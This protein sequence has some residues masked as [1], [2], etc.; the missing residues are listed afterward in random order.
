M[1]SVQNLSN[2]LKIKMSQWLQLT[3]NFQKWKIS[4]LTRI[5]S[6]PCCIIFSCSSKFHYIN[7][8]NPL[9]LLKNPLSVWETGVV[10]Q[11]LSLWYRILR[12]Y[13]ICFLFCKLK[14]KVIRKAFFIAFYL[15]SKTNWL[16]H[17][18][19]QYLYPTSLF[20]HE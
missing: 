20:A 15:L 11:I 9:Y 5:L 18:S 7:F 8:F 14:H 16:H 17:I 1:I 12:Y 4:N 10:V 2:H 19:Q 13:K 6:F 3:A